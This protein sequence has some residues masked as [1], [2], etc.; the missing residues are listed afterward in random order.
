MDKTNQKMVLKNYPKLE[1]I[2]KEVCEEKG[3]NYRLMENIWKIIKQSSRFNVPNRRK[4]E[5][6]RNLIHEAM[7]D[8]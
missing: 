6:I 2:M 4:S 5:K 8:S 1:V 3:I 7:E